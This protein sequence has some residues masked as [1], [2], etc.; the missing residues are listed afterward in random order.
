MKTFY[1]I[2]VFTILTLQSAYGQSIEN[3]F[4]SMETPEGQTGAKVIFV[5]DS[6]IETI[7]LK[8]NKDII[9][10]G[11][12]VFSIQV[13]SSNQRSAK[14]DATNIEHQLR[15]KFPDSNIKVN[16]ISPFW[17]VRIGEFSTREEANKFRQE[18]IGAM[19]A[20]RD[21]IYIVADRNP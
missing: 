11:T 19:P 17:K 18:V 14:S 6:S 21:Q 16:Y 7:F 10:K 2:S 12:N 13:F 3:I 20:Q 8:K 4:I 9:Q 15:S 1:F 5:H